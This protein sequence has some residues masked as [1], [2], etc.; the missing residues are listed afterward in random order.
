MRPLRVSTV[1]ARNIGSETLLYNADEE[2]IHVLNPVAKLI[3]DL[4]DG[5][6]APEDMEQII[7]QNFSVSGAHNVGSDV[8]RTLGTFAEKGLLKTL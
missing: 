3:W 7:R 8:Q 5:E 2:V 1:I 6:H 4:C